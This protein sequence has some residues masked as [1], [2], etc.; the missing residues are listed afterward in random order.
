MAP[1]LQ[2]LVERHVASGTVPGAVASSAAR[3]SKIVAAGVTSVRGP[4]AVTQPMRV[5]SIT[6]WAL[7]LDQVH[8]L[9]GIEALGM[10]GVDERVVARCAVHLPV[11]LRGGLSS[12][13]GAFR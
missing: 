3:R 8:Q 4:W 9:V 2:D 11:V 1:A 12:M 7:T 5:Q 10:P 13:P 6:Y